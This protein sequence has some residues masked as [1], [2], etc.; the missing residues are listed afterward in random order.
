MMSRHDPGAGEIAAIEE[1]DPVLTASVF[2]APSS[3]ARAPLS[4]IR[5][6]NEAIVRIGFP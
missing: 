1:G 6:A 3:V 2:R 5:A 4:P